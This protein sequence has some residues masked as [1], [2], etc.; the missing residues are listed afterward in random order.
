MGSAAPFDDERTLSRR[1]RDRSWLSATLLDVVLE[2]LGGE[3]NRLL[4]SSVLLFGLAAFSDGSSILVVVE[5]TRLSSSASLRNEVVRHLGDVRGGI[6]AAVSFLADVSR[7][8]A[9]KRIRRGWPFGFGS[10]SS[11]ALLDDVLLA[12]CLERERV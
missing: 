1:E 11:A 8:S 6:L 2:H 12:F 9:G 3:G 4:H 7:F 10:G 5:H